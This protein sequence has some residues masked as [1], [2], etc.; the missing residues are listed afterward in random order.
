MKRL[1]VPGVLVA[2]YVLGIAT[3]ALGF[4]LYRTYS[5]PPSPARWQG[6]FDRERYVDRL[7]QALQLQEGQR[8]QLDRILDDAR[9][10]FGKLRQTIHP[11]AQE[12][13]QQ[14]RARIREMLSPDQQ[15]RFEAFV[16]EWEAERQR[17]RER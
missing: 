12:I 5:A 14:A 13:K 3:G 11:Q 4:T 15:R 6:R 9:D 16:E 7:T 8:Q 1:K 17:R 10:E 2:V